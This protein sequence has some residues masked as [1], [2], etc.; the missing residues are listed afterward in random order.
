MSRIGKQPVVIPQ[1]VSVTIAGASVK[2]KGPLGELAETLPMSMSAVVT[3]GAV[4]VSADLKADK[5][6]NAFFGTSRARINNMVE[7]VSKGFFKDMSIVGLG[8]RAEADAKKITIA[9]GKAHPVL[10]DI[11]TGIKVKID[12]NTT[13]VNFSGIDKAL[14]GNTAARFGSPNKPEPHKGTA[15]QYKAEPLRPQPGP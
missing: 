15:T 14:V 2:V 9:L 5:R 1:G 13:Q 11:P 10:F 7:G 3:D 12:P 8:F 6:A 4:L